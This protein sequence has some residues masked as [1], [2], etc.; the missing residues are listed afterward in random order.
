MTE[1]TPLDDVPNLL[2]L[3]LTALAAA[4]EAPMLWAKRDGTWQSWSRADVARSV[5]SLAS[6]LERHGLAPGDR[7]VI[8]SEN[9]PEW[10]IADLAILSAGAIVA[11]AYTTYTTDDHRHL[12]TDSGA[13]MVIV[14]TPALLEKAAPAIAEMPDGGTVIAMQVP[15]ATPDIGSAVIHPW[16]DLANPQEGVE[17]TE[18][19]VRRDRIKR[20]DTACI[21]Y[22]SGTGGSPKGVMLSHGNIMANAG[23]ALVLLREFG[24]SEDDVF[25]SFLPLSHSYE[26][27]VGTYL[28]MTFGGQL[29]FAQGV[30]TLMNDIKEVKPTLMTAVPRLY[31]AIHDRTLR[32]AGRKG[33]LTK[34]LI[35]E[36]VR[37]GRKRY[38]QGGRL[39]PIDAL[40]DMVLERLVRRK[41]RERFGGRLKALVSGG[42]PLNPDLGLFLHCLGLTVLQGYGQ[43]ETSPVVSVNPPW[44]IKMHTVGPPLPGVE[45]GFGA[46][47]EILVRGELVMKGYWN[48][49]K[50]TANVIRDGW[51]HTGDIGH[52]DEDGYLVITDR[53]KDIIVN[54]GGDNISP[55]RVEGL[56]CLSPAISQAVVFGDR[57]PYL[58]A[59][60]VPDGD[61]A[62]NWA[63]EN[64]SAREIGVVSTNPDFQKALQSEIEKANASLQVIEK[65]RKIVVANQPFAIDT[66][67][68]TPTLKIKRH[69]IKERY[70]E[71]LEALYA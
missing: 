31:Q 27:T 39:G 28:P 32:D 11:P 23:G 66:G 21:I 49:P 57:R 18:L 29:Y 48:R 44:K 8:L 52:L 16:A 50:E 19:T 65:V 34:K 40:Y 51:L 42:A 60:V 68:M 55:Q 22:T 70:G 59:V 35:E 5:R 14:S 33:K 3:F 58:V 15:D 26:H 62:L 64:G 36:T 56:L 43:T 25:L 9:R 13:K 54:S 45:I 47:S 41:V 69:V 61:F 20:T 67:E 30:E 1:Q 17:E 37:I 2:A 63:K 7:V 12:L 6:N 24:V 10:I 38:D 53:K 46:D 4:P 71:R